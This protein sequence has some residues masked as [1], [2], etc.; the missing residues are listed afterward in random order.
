MA[1]VLAEA[2]VEL[3]ADIS[4]FNQ[5]FKK[6]LKQAEKDAQSTTDDID[7]SFKQLSGNL[8]KEF[9]QAS[10]EIARQYREQEREAQRVQR[11]IE[12]EA[13]RTARALERE[14][15][16]ARRAWERELRA[17]AREN[18]RVQREIEAEIKRT[19]REI[20]RE[21]ERVTREN[22]KAQKEFEREFIASQRAMEK[23]QAEAQK[24][25]TDRFRD[26]VS[27]LRKFASER[28]SLSLGVDTS[29][30]TSAL[31]TVSKLGAVL[32]GIGIGALAGQAS[33]A[34]LASVTIA[35][36]ELIGSI[37][38]L[39]A[40]GA[41]AGI[42]ISTLTLGL[43]GL[44][45]A[46]S[47]DKPQELE[48]ALK[49]LSKN[50]QSFVKTVRDLKDEFEDLSKSVQNVLLENFSKE[51]EELAK[52]FLPVLHKGF[53]QVAAEIN[54]GALA[55]SDFVRSGHT[56][57]EVERIFQNTRQAVAIFRRSAL[58]P[59]AETFRDITAVGS[60]FL[61]VI[62]ADLDGLVNRFAD[63]IRTARETGQLTV[64]FERA[65]QSVRDFFAVIGNLGSIFNSIMNVAEETLGGGFLVL[66]RNL[67][68]NIEDFLESLEGQV[69]LINF[70]EGAR[71][72]AKL[73]LPILGDLARLILEVVL[74]A[75][76]KLGVVAAPGLN[77]LV[78]GLRKGLE[79]A[80]PGIISFVDSLSS[81]VV[82]LVDA[83][84]LDAL[85]ELVRVLGTSLGAAI[86][87]IAPKLGELI[88]SILV[89]LI[90]ILPR[91]LPGLAKFA[92][93]LADLVIAALPVVDVLADIV[94]KVGLPTLQRIAE[95]L[96]PIVERLARS[97]GEVLLP[98]LPDL[99]D[100]FEELIDALA[101]VVD[102]I[103]A[104]LI[105]L[106]K[107]LVP[108]LPSIVRSITELVKAVLPVIK[109]FADLA[110]V[111]SRS[112][113]KLYEI[114][115]V[116]KFMEEQLPGLLA[117]LTGTLIVPL[118]KLLEL[119]DQVITKLDEAGVF[120]LFIA[121][122]GTL[123]DALALTSEGFRRWGQYFDN[124]INF[125]KEVARVGVELI[126]NII[127]TGFEAIKNFFI[128]IWEIINAIVNRAWEFIKSIVRT[129]VQFVLSIVT[130]G[131][132]A[133]PQ[134]VQDALGRMRDAVGDAF[135]RLLDLIRDIP[136]RIRGALG[137]LGNLLYQAGR[138]LVNGMI[139]GITSAVG[140]LV[141][142]AANMA[143][144][145]L[146]AAK[147]AIGAKSPSRKMMVVGEDFGAGFV[148]GIENMLRQASAAGAELAT[149]AVQASTTALAPGDNSVYRM[150]E[151]LNRLTRN[152]LGPAPALQAPSAT[153]AAAPS[154]VTITPEVHV[155]IGN[156]EIDDHI[157]EIVDD[158][159]RRIKRSLT[160]GARRIV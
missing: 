98:V 72:A 83:G 120:D 111:V 155:Y 52:T 62:A 10:R 76:T 102:E 91:I 109:V 147:S 50:G 152:G 13:E 122:L 129:A 105:E 63:F 70:F 44:G 93:A 56:V 17:I 107:A 30:I 104:A 58:V 43:R 26:H 146:N 45:D 35:I 143:T 117:L 99:A 151:T 68:Q 40:V 64:F 131:F 60:D 89:K 127:F 12:R 123:G 137:N 135:N 81:V 54:R 36:Q 108:L 7:K 95:A 15:R 136:N 18:A 73:I 139:N 38:L 21:T 82:S 78:D 145:A 87:S 71:D 90:E 27:A 69:A 11:E 59:L 130:S 51:V 5:E 8:G 126:A 150:N 142:T 6:S 47:A 92:G 24:R 115:G 113:T 128:T 80:I 159:D 75:F 3:E 20:E 61:P 79:S 16:D 85:G 88:N 41:S 28:L 84:V 19:Q 153:T 144:D 148:I 67:T 2:V 160:M 149:Q 94:S 25:A 29:Q 158:H 49:N 96:T 97:I 112:L 103:L 157:T 156:K 53:T 48:E 32:G 57:K 138:D 46:I 133:L 33:V 125:L 132:G 65:I 74:P 106:L 77:A 34:G 9:E 22:I 23:A 100:A 42:V 39:P 86:R 114:P 116:K 154:N 1:D 141:T 118:G 121:A 66:L 4:K 31:G 140:G 101:P 124:T 14:A 110:E 37:A 119:L 55:L 134:V